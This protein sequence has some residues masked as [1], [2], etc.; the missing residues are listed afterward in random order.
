MLKKS[1]NYRASLDKLKGKKFYSLSEAIKLLKETSTVKFNATAEL[2]FNLNVD[3][4]KSEQNIRGTVALPHGSGKTLKIAAVVPEDKVKIAKAAGAAEAGLENLIEEFSKGKINYD[5]IVATPNVMKNL[6][7][8]A[9]ILGQK[10]VM[11]NPKSG[12]V[13]DNIEKTIKELMGGR[14][15]YRN[16]KESNVHT[17]FGKLSFKEEELENN[18][19]TILRAIKNAKPSTVKGTFINSI[20]IASTM[21]PGIRLNVNET[22]KSL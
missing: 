21:G 10:G 8:V 16:D 19:K 11:P 18:L 20:T 14:V 3:P 22:L 15:E 2:H 5:I 12:T 7:K 1:K 13:T 4:K 17:I 9:K 6:G